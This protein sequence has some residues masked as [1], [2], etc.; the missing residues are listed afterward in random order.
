MTRLWTASI[1]LIIALGCG[2]DTISGPNDLLPNAEFSTYYI[3][4]GDVD[5]GVT[6]SRDIVIKNT[7]KLSMGIGTVALGTGE[8]E[9]NFAL[10]WSS[11]DLSCEDVEEDA[12]DNAAALA[13]AEATRQKILEIN[14][15]ILEILEINSRILEF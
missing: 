4:F 13:A 3:D 2:E 1:P 10:S 11:L 15:R 7:G 8:M 12:E 6:L 9:D 14:S 5:W